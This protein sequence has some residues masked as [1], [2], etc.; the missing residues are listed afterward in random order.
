[1]HKSFKKDIEYTRN[2]IENWRTDPGISGGG[3]F[4]DLA[5]HQLDI[6]DW[7]FG[8]I[9]SAKGFALNQA[10]LYKADD[11][12]LGQFQFESGIAGQGS[13][14]FTTSENAETEITTFYGSKGTL[15]FPFFGDHSVSLHLDGMSPEKHE[16]DIPLHI[17]L[18]LIQSI[19]DDL[20]GIGSCPSTGI[21]AARTNKIMDMILA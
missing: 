10:G 21:T 15:S 16:F 7:I 17:Q 1:V 5:C 9:K 13:W 19:V 20:R 3:Y 18:P 8:P 2:K 4:N 6:L 11:L 12:V 14:C